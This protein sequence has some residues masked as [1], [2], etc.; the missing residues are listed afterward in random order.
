MTAVLPTTELSDAPARRR[1]PSEWARCSA[2][3]VGVAGL[4]VTQPVLD[5]FGRNPEFFVAGR[6]GRR[7]IVLFALAV[8]LVPAA[9]AVAT[10]TVAW[11][12][13]PALGA[14]AYGAALA[15]FGTL[16]ALVVLNAL[17]VDVVWQAVAA[18]LAVAALLVWL[19]RT[20]R[21]VRSMLSYLAVGNV[22]F[23]LLFLFASPTAELVAG[24]TVPGA[25]GVAAPVLG[26]P[27]V[28]LVL[29]EFPLTTILRPD[30][31]IDEARYPNMARLAAGSTWFRNASSLHPLTKVSVPS[32]LTGTVGEKGD[33]PTSHDHPRSY[34]TLFG[35]RYPI[36][37]Y[38]A[39]T[40]M[41]PPGL[42]GDD[43]RGA[44]S[45]ALRDG[46]I[47]Y[48]HQ[49]LPGELA[50]ELPSIDHS[51]GGFGDDMGPSGPGAAD[52]PDQ[53]VVGDDGYGRWHSLDPLDRSPSGQAAAMAQA[54]SQIGAGPSVNF[55]HVAFPHYPWVL[56]PWGTSLTQFPHDL[57]DD[58]QDSRYEFLSVLRYQLHALQVGAADV[59]VGRM[60]DRLRSVGAWDDALVVVTSDHGTSLT[61]PDFGRTLTEANREEVLRIPL[62]VKAPGQV[63]GEVRDEPALTIDVLPSI[64]DLL[65]V[66]TGWRFDGHSLFD[67][68]RPTRAPKVDDDL[69]P[70]LDV[71]AGHARDVPGEG[72]EGLV[73]TGASGDLVGTPL[74]DLALGR[75]SDLSWT[76]DDRPLFA[77]LPTDDGRVPY[78][79]TGSVAS[80]DDEPP[81]VLVAVNGT[82]AGS[83]GAFSASDG[84]GRTFFA[85]LGPFFVDGANTV[86][87]YEVERTP[88]GPLLHR[89]ADA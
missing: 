14:T 60:I 38:E 39:V 28:V 32:I 1:S 23:V 45:T 74:G 6:Y 24:T 4:A 59:A 67:G 18:A 80:G 75:P 15:G 53:T 63:S 72:W 17:E 12:A 65:D 78:L 27:V 48:G 77:S 64:V 89:L 61:A 25:E 21:P 36:N 83:M 20:R 35:D 41:L 55:I 16:F 69:A 43:V 33:L 30:G 31:T 34:L 58:P 50:D 70:A 9:V 42:G 81:E 51:W 49:V 84:G 76:A 57:A 56:T 22:A 85:L 68:S 46:S 66:R 7:E 52:P 10:T 73:S 5:V 82:V 11:L 87:A 13:H 79:L 62:F 3:L 37:T 19:D 86:E 2:A 26:G 88:L 44:I 29:D 47:V 40:D 71:A 54:V 8:A